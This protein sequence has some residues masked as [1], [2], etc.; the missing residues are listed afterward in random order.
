MIFTPYIYVTPHI[1]KIWVNTVGG[2]RLQMSWV[3]QSS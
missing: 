2:N 1:S 3:V